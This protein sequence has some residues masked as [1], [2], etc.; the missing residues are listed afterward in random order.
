MKK[1]LLPTDFSENAWNAIAYAL[2]LFKNE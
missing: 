2:E 1:I